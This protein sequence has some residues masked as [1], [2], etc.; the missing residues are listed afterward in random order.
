LR[1][2]VADFL[3][4]NKLM[5]EYPD[6][7]DSYLEPAAAAKL[8]AELVP[9]VDAFENDLA[10]LNYWFRDRVSTTLKAN[11][12]KDL[13]YDYSGIVS[14]KVVASN[15]AL[16]ETETQ[17]YFD[18]T[19]PN[20]VASLANGLS[21]AE[22]NQPKVLPGDLK[23]NAVAGGL[24]ALAQL[25][26][27]KQYAKVG[28]DLNLTVTPYSLSAADGA[29]MDIEITSK[30]N[31]VGIFGSAT[32]GTSAPDDFASRV[33]SH[34]VKSHVRLQSLK[35]FELSTLDSMLARSK[36][37]WKPVDPYLEIPVLGD[38]VRIPRR[39]D[40]IHEQ[41]VVFIS[42]VVVPT[43]ADLA[44]APIEEDTD[45][46]DNPPLGKDLHSFG[47][48]WP[49]VMDGIKEYHKRMLGCFARTQ[50]DASGDVSGCDLTDVRVDDL[51]VAAGVNP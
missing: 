39:P 10:V 13:T 4:Q 26:P 14:V 17:N 18:A 25:S 31:G 12:R 7:F 8:D 44:S 51:G 40:L 3:F 41:S 23:G 42:A 47:A 2:A 11:T 30:E 35:L 24:A 22:A 1:A 16:V 43:A 50:T 33:A 32:S 27:G 38:F 48:D 36:S 9:F 29:E 15:Q 28:K 49:H 6:E 45:V 46:I 37:P 34:H 19:P 20:T 21:T 5:V